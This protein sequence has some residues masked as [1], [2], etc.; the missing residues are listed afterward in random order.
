MISVIQSFLKEKYLKKNDLPT[1]MYFKDLQ[2]PF[3][4]NVKP[5]RDKL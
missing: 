3:I 1:I 4:I 2:L 5:V